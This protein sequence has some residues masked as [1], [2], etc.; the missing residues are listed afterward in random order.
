MITGTIVDA[1]CPDSR[2]ERVTVE[3]EAS[4]LAAHEAV[5]LPAV[6]V[7][8]R[9]HAVAL[10]VEARTVLAPG[11]LRRTWIGRV[12][13]F[14]RISWGPCPIAI[15]VGGALNLDTRAK[16]RAWYVNTPHN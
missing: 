3:P 1:A 11:G 14:S 7:V 10:G 2:P 12:G 15:G 4:G 16:S 9:V 6:L 13:Y 8:D 5:E